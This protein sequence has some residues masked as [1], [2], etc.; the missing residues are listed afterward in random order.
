MVETGAGYL[1]AY[2]E[3]LPR[4]A[5]CVGDARR[6]VAL[7]L[8]VWGLD[9][10]RDA[11]ELVVSELMTNAVLHAARDSVRVTVTH[12]GEGRVQVVVTDMSKEL[13][14]YRVADADQKSGRGLGIVDALSVGRWGVAPVRWGKRVW[15]VLG[16]VE[17]GLG[18]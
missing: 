17:V 10:I 6:L 11:A 9:E 7:A 2:A 13:P 16:P 8:D 14:T 3:T 12:L 4:S 5:G 18:E 15:A 1:P